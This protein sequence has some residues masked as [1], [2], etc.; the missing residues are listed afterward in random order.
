[1]VFLTGPP[2]TWIVSVLRYLNYDVVFFTFTGLIISILYFNKNKFQKEYLVFSILA[3]GMLLAGI[4]VPS[5]EVS[6]NISRIYEISF[7]FLAPFCIIGALNIVKYIYTT[8]NKSKIDSEKSLK[9]FSVFLVIFLFFNAGFF[10]VLSNQSV[11]MHLSGENS[12]SDYHPRFDY[13]EVLGAQWLSQ[14]RVEGKIFAD[15][16]GVF[17]FYRYIT[18]PNQ[19]STNNG[20]YTIAEY[21]KSTS[22][23]YLRKLNQ[24]NNLLVG[25]TSRTNR[26]R[27]YEDMSNL[28]N[29]KNRIYENGASKIYY[30]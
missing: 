6:F 22:Y 10:S 14:K 16:Y 17:I 20:V 27:V 5:F 7:L 13:Q 12:A 11:P 4:V 21:D 15:V 26:N 30:G 28:I 24:D 29:S 23:I 3:A 19:I 9:I 8:I 18:I 2:K 1:M 25:F